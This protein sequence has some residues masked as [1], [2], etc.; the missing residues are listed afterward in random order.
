MAYNMIDI[1]FEHWRRRIKIIDDKR[2]YRVIH[3]VVTVFAIG[4][5]TFCD[6]LFLSRSD[7]VVV[8][9][10]CNITP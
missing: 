5:I 8:K 10:F 3:S 6:I 4:I 7:I 2:M 1:L 9:H